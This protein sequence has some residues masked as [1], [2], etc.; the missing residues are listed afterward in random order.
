MTTVA[1]QVSATLAQTRPASQQRAR[2]S[3]VPEQTEDPPKEAEEAIQPRERT[4]CGHLEAFGGRYQLNS[5][6]NPGFRQASKT[7]HGLVG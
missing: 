6:F 3:E 2:H 7:L 5:Q 4:I 1:V